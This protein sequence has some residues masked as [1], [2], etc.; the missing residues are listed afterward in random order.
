MNFGAIQRTNDVLRELPLVK[1]GSVSAAYALEVTAEC[2]FLRG[3]YESEL[4][5][6][7]RNVPYIDETVNYANGNYSVGNPGPVWD[8]IEA[9]LTFAMTNLPVTQPQIGRANKYAAEAFLAKAYMYEHK[10]AQAKPL[11]EDLIA[12]GANSNGVKYA[13]GSYGNNFNPSTKNGAEGVFVI[14]TSVH[15]G[16]N[17]A[18]GNS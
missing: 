12:N 18:N 16:S 5:K 9:D 2:R 8:K 10:Y 1:D 4:E 13:L 14:Q 15:D 17:G 11:L 6:L 3:F 7:W